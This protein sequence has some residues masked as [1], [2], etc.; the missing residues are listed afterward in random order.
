MEYAKKQERGLVSLLLVVTLLANLCVLAGVGNSIGISDY[1]LKMGPSSSENMAWTPNGTAICTKVN[2]QGGVHLV[3]DEVSG[4][5]MTWEDNRDGNYNIYA[6]RVDS[7]GNALW[8][9]NGTVICNATSTQLEPQITSDDASGAIITWQD[10]RNGNYDIYAQ[11]VNSAGVTQWDDNGT[12][13]CNTLDDETLPQIV[14]D[15]N[16][17]AIITWEVLLGGSSYNVYA[18]KVDAEGNPQWDINGIPLYNGLES[19]P[20]ID[21]RQPQIASDG[22]GGAIFTWQSGAD[23]TWNLQ[24]QRINATGNRKWGVSPLGEAGIIICNIGND[25]KDAQIVSDG[26]G[27][28]IITWEDYRDGN[29]DV[30]AQRVNTTGAIQW[31][32]NGI[33]ICNATGNQY[34]PKLVSDASS[35][36][37]ITW[38]DGRGSTF[39]IY[40]QRVNYAGVGLWGS[41]GT[42]ICTETGQERYPQLISDGANGAIITWNDDRLGNNDIYAQRVNAAGTFK[43]VANGTSVCTMSESQRYPQLASD[44]TGGAII[45]WDDYRNSN[46]DIFAQRVANLPPTANNPADI[47]TSVTG[48]ETINWVLTDDQGSGQY[49][50]LVTN[51]SVTNQEWVAL[52]EWANVVALNVPIDR[53]TSGNASYTI[54]YTDDQGVAGISDT[55]VVMVTGGG[56]PGFQVVLLLMVTGCVT[57]YLSHRARRISRA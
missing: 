50:V 23:G 33:T 38:Q 11:R 39:D 45:A 31:S 44:G 36:A 56:I 53:S 9:P 32:A 57:F 14:S 27:G 12:V 8:S 17:G 51:S 3:S 35:G 18:Q 26:V 4:V 49:R 54:E 10:G 2:G 48:S 40:A 30:Y 29:S 6:Q 43:W 22:V 34:S 21:K 16:G 5:I 25:Q 20:P 46:Y 28:A 37:I 24:A 1:S 55:V 15:G 19:L 47:S 42:A 13:I 7:A 52:T 41:N